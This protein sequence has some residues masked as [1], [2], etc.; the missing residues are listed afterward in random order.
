MALLQLNNICRSFQNGEQQVQVLHNINLAIDSGEFVAIV[1]QSGSGKSTLMNILGCL[2]KSSAGEYRIADRAVSALD[3]DALAALR[4]EHFGFIFQRYHLLS[5]L[6]ALGNAEM[7]AIY[8][9]QAVQARR[10]RAAALL[11]RLG[12][13]ERLHYR[14]GQLSGGQ[15]QRVSIARALMNGGEVILAD[16]PTGALDSHSGEEVM[17]ILHDLHQQGHTIVIVTHDMQ[18]AQHAQRIIEIRDGEILSD[19]RRQASAASP[20]QMTQRAAGKAWRAARDR[21]TEAF[22]M[23]L[24]SMMSQRLRTFLTMLGIIIGIASV[25]AVVALGKGSQQKILQEIS[26]MGTSTLDI[27]PGNDFG[28]MHSSAIQTLRA[29]DADALAYQPYVHSVTPSLSTTTTLKYRNQALSVMV[30]GVGEQFFA[31]RGYQLTQGMAFN[32]QGVDSLTQEAVIDEN[33]LKRL[34]PHGEKPLGQVVIL[35]NMPVRIIGVATR[36]SS[37]G[38]DS[39]LNLWVPYTTVMKRM[40]GQTWLSGITV[41]VRDNVDLAL[42]EQGVTRLLTQRHNGKDFFILNTDSI[43]QTIE[44]TTNTMTLL[45]AMIALIS[46][47]VGGIG[48]MNIMLVSVTE[49]TREIGVRMAVGARASDIMQQFLIEAV[50]VCLTGGIIGVL[51]SL[52][53]GII[54]AQTTNSFSMIYSPFS[55]VAAFVCS[56]LIGVLF[57]FFPARRAARLDPIHALERE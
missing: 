45:V 44:R 7:P 41:R 13:G 3:N 21:L 37:F 47:L 46:L 17:R 51:L 33:T 26:A 49:R 4:R 55:I 18:I 30:N 52:V 36:Q 11:T 24:V 19:S 6:T 48:V 56:S 25:V 40:V 22:R 29:S 35:G 14:P 16:E 42:A 8:A 39:N 15:Q 43:R 5:E 38:S 20:R 9:G 10:E 53:P 34:F 1:G 50:L 23:A 28:D 2:D 27:F 54:L 32:R 57:G 12:L 31:V